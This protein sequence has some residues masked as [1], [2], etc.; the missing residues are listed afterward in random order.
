MEKWLRANAQYGHQMMGSALGCSET[1]S[2]RRCRKYGI[3]VPA[4]KRQHGLAHNQNASGKPSKPPKMARAAK[5]KMTAQ[6]RDDGYRLEALSAENRTLRQE[7]QTVKVDLGRSRM[8]YEEVLAAIPRTVVQPQRYAPAVHKG[9]PLAEFV[10]AESDWH[11]GQVVSKEQTGG[12]GQYNWQIQQDRVALFGKKVIAYLETLRHSYRI[13]RIRVFQLGDPV[14][15]NLHDSPETNEWPV[16]K[17]VTNG[18]TL[19]AEHIGSIAPHAKTVVVE[20]L[21]TDNHG[22]TTPKYQ[23]TQAGTNTYSY[24]FAEAVKDKLANHKRVA[25]N[26]HVPTRVEVKIGQCNFLLE[27]GNNYLSWLGIPYYGLARGVRTEAWRRLGVPEREFQYMVLGHFH[28][29]FSLEGGRIIGVPSIVGP[30]EFSDQRGMLG[31][32]AQTAFL[33]GKYG[34]FARTDFDLGGAK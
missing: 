2:Q 30:S 18:A 11:T 9:K 15:G 16:P 24:M 8:F 28:Q 12:W 20:I 23:A 10:I 4:V 31:E 14:N 13:D 3:D 26:V 33:V 32:P 21:T 27:H 25:V 19:C 6:A 7:N 29:A 1:E 34:A 5:P 17:Q 22:R